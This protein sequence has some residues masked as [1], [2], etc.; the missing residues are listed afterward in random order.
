MY[1]R[2]FFWVL[3][4][5]FLALKPLVC[6]ADDEYRRITKTYPKVAMSTSGNF[7]LVWGDM[8]HIY[9]QRYDFAGDEIGETI[10]VDVNIPTQNIL[11]P[12]VQSHYVSMDDEGN[13]VVAWESSGEFR[14]IHFRLFDIDA[15]TVAESTD[16]NKL[17]PS[18]SMSPSG[19]FALAYK[20]LTQ[21]HIVAQ[22]F[23]SKGNPISSVFPVSSGKVRPWESDVSMDDEGN[24]VVAFEETKGRNNIYVSV[25][26]QLNQVLYLVI[27]TDY[28]DAQN[29]AVTIDPNGNI[30]MVWE[31]DGPIWYDSGA[32]D[33]EFPP[34]IVL[35]PGEYIVVCGDP[36]GPNFYDINNVAGFYEGEL[37]NKEG[38]IAL[39]TSYGNVID[40]VEYS[41]SPPWPYQ[42]DGG[43]PSLELIN[44]N[45]RVNWGF[46]QPYSPGV[47]NNPA[48]PHREDIMISEVMYHPDPMNMGGE[49]I[50]LY[51]RGDTPLILDGW[52]LEVGERFS[53]K[54]VMLS[55]LDN[56]GVF[57]V[58]QL[59]VNK[60]YPTEDSAPGVIFNENG[61]IVVVYSALKWPTEER[62]VFSRRYSLSEGTLSEPLW[63]NE[64]T[65]PEFSNTN[66]SI[67]SGPSGPYVV[68][69]ETYVLDEDGEF[70]HTEQHFRIF[71]K[72]QCV[73]DLNGDGIVD[74]K[75]LAIFARLWLW[76]ALWRRG[77]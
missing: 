13:F 49:Y 35:E 70:D 1:K 51:N 54:N 40:M 60:K 52:R 34:G 67:A 37:D 62:H 45:N 72:E 46:G 59:I 11:P 75:D 3:I 7:V 27:S 28:E 47:A 25:F 53:S 69:W 29:P 42:A 20:D 19:N 5:F 50:E 48:Q 55:V 24:L 66:P 57:I 14:E 36:C 63:V 71:G 17:R 2:A 9:A 44:P 31:E 23:D 41:D 56:N 65:S 76:E 8:D 15:N 26:D 74:L 4:A 39:T 32:F 58:E 77:R 18:V 38:V 12:D 10:E 21:N 33:F 6:S 22:L 43:G 73:A 30:A 64:G 61:N 68:A 16:P